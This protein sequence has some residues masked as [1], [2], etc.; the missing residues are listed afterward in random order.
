MVDTSHSAHPPMCGTTLTRAYESAAEPPGPAETGV[1]E[2]ARAGVGASFAPDDLKS[3]LL[4]EIDAY[5]GAGA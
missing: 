2:L 1:A 4:G 5:V 3:R